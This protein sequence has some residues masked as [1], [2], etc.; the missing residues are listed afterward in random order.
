MCLTASSLHSTQ[1]L[2]AVFVLPPALLVPS[3]Q[4]KPST[5][6][7]GVAS[8][9]PDHR[10]S[11]FTITHTPERSHSSATSQAVADLSAFSRISGVTRS[12]TPRGATSP[13]WR[14]R[15]SISS[16]HLDLAEV[17]KDTGLVDHLRLH[18]RPD[19]G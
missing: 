10:V 9:S 17:T 8:V 3:H 2:L 7:H 15:V 18:L 4:V 1:V 14:L 16:K 11:R 12:V 19:Q 13:S 5:N 6:V